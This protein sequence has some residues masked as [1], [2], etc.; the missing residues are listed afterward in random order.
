ML[1]TKWWYLSGNLLRVGVYSHQFWVRFPKETT[2]W[3]VWTW[4]SVQV[5]YMVDRNKR[6]VYPRTIIERY[7]NLDQTVLYAFG[8]VHFAAVPNSQ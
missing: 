3:P 7:S 8:L 6:S 5:I 4:T 2:I 1:L